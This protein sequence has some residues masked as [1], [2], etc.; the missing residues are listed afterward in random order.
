MKGIKYYLAFRFLGI[1]S[2][3][4]PLLDWIESKFTKPERWKAPT[5][6]AIQSTEGTKPSSYGM[7]AQEA[8]IKVGILAKK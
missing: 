6:L 1:F 2:K 5:K 4:N 7:W 8:G 3:I